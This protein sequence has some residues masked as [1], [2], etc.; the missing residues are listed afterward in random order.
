M[1]GPDL[2]IYRPTQSVRDFYVDAKGGSD[3]ADGKT[4]GTAWK[5]L[6][7]LHQVVYTPGDVIHLARGSVWENTS[8]MFDNASAGSAQAPVVIEA[9]GVGEPP[10]LSKPKALWDPSKDF[11][12][13]AFGAQ[14]AYITVLDLR[15]QDYNSAVITMDQGSQHLVIAGVE[16]L[17]C[18]MGIG[19]HGQHHKVIGNYIHDGVMAVDTGN[20]DVDWGANGVGVVGQDIEVAWNRFVNCTAASKAFGQDGGA[21]EFFGWEPNATD[22]NGWHY[23]SDNIRIHHNWADHCNG[24][25]EA[26]GYVTN[27]LLA[28]NVYVHGPNEVLE[29]HMDPAT[30]SPPR[31]GASQLMYF[32]YQ[33][34]IENNT[35]V[36]DQDPNPGGWGI[37]GLLVDWNRL[38]DPKAQQITIRNNIFLTNFRAVGQN[39]IGSS[40]IHDHNLYQLF[41]AGVVSGDS[42]TFGLDATE[43]VTD[44]QFLDAAHLDFRLKVTSP[45]VD[46]GVATSFPVDLLGTPVPTG[47]APDIG[48][49]EWH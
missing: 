34:R 33:A 16:I 42:Q 26:S 19:V 15:L 35:F 49:Y 31:G 11:Q 25:M 41:G 12:A 40:L 13:I 32:A 1:A 36:P 10:T 14:S 21:V 27:L 39:V 43:K 3:S 4:P 5:S 44:P 38:P 18:A 45:A 9:Y 46:K 20:P 23:V 2:N 6:S 29:F 47:A 24:F 22:D 37:V 28:Y 7:K 17:R 8:L 48:A 30:Y